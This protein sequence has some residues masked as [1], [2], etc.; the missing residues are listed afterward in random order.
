MSHVYGKH[1]G[2]TESEIQTL[3]NNIVSN[4]LVLDN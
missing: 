1:D 4:V 3:F 2:D